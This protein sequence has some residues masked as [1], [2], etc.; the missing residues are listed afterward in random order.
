MQ[1][2]R[3]YRHYRFPRREWLSLDWQFH[4]P[5]LNSDANAP[6]YQAC[7]GK[8]TC[9]AP[10]LH[11]RGR[12]SDQPLLSGFHSEHGSGGLG[13]SQSVLRGFVHY[14]LP[15]YILLMLI[16]QV[17][18]GASNTAFMTPFYL[19]HPSPRRPLIPTSPTLTIPGLKF[20]LSTTPIL[21]SI[22]G[23]TRRTIGFPKC[24]R[25]RWQDLPTI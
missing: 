10:L 3:Q 7:I 22:L 1:S 13:T 19:T 6:R 24:I 8:R 9:N 14:P 4:I 5:R 21:K 23:Q 16:A 18:A 2:L 20:F 25:R 17:T 15:S 12:G 11:P